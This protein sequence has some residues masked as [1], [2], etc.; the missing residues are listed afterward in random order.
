LALLATY[1][2]HGFTGFDKAVVVDVETTGLD[3]KSDRIVAVACLRGSIAEFATKGFTHL[4]QFT[5]RLDPGIPIPPEA[6]RAHGIKDSDVTGQESFGDIAAQLRDFIGTL[7]LIAHN[8]SHDKA[9]LSEEFKRAGQKSLHQNKAYCTMKRL[10]E[11]FGYSQEVWR[12]LSLAEA[13]AHFG[14]NNNRAGPYHDPLEDALLTLQL[15]GGLYQLDNGIPPRTTEAS[16]HVPATRTPTTVWGGRQPVL[17]VVVAILAVAALGWLFSEG[18][19]DSQPR[20]TAPDVVAPESE[21]R[22]VPHG[23]DSIPPPQPSLAIPTPPPPLYVLVTGDAVNVRAG[24]SIHHH[25]VGRAHQGDRAEELGRSG[26]WV[27]LRLERNR[28]E[29]YMHSR[30]V[31]PTPPTEAPVANRAQDVPSSQ[32]S[33]NLLTISDEAIRQILVQESVARYAGS[34]PCPYNVDRGGRRCGGRSAYSRPVGA[35]PYCYASDVP[36]TAVAGYRQRSAAR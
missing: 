6:T 20:R 10:R 25:V 35:S 13:A 17:L 8:T 12:N 28:L 15:A 27:R 31:A 7:P 16:G 34:C 32:S 22:L 14:L 11:H 33:P 3:P 4:D 1:R 21:T 23:T 29:G 2:D 19:D 36:A 26:G 24:P 5:A 9:F 30:Y 18:E